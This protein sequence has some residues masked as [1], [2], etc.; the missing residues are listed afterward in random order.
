[1]PERR[2]TLVWK[3]EDGPADTTVPHPDDVGP[4]WLMTPGAPD[5]TID[6]GGWITRAD[7]TR[8]AAAKGWCFEADDGLGEETANAEPLLDVEAV[9]LRLRSLGVGEDELVL[10]HAEDGPG[11]DLAGTLADE[12]VPM[13][14]LLPSE[15]RSPV[16]H[17]F[18]TD[19][20]L[21]A[22]L[23][24]LAPT[25]ER[26]NRRL[27]ERRLRQTVYHPPRERLA[28]L[29]SP[30]G[31]PATASAIGFLQS[32]GTTGTSIGRAT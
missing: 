14:P 13:P 21:A 3:Y 22:K 25:G 20:G 8:L 19:A 1:M 10:L 32:V 7:A 29:G 17:Y 4:A 15:R 9:N 16:R 28:W 24:E 6:D 27:R 11:H 12:G 2:S 18:A 5:K 31:I 30:S 26:N 23:D